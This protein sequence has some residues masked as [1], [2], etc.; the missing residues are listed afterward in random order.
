M[1]LEIH[2]TRIENDATEVVVVDDNESC[3][4]VTPR[5]KRRIKSPQGELDDTVALLQAA[6]EH[7]I[8]IVNLQS[9]RDDRRVTP[10]EECIALKCSDQA[11]RLSI[12]R[13]KLDLEKI[14]FEADK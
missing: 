9:E 13:Q 3:P 2:A 4:T 8:R 14:R 5:K 1:A 12:E 7:R 10:E 11:D 6:E